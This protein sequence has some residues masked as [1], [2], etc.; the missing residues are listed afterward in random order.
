M[1]TNGLENVVEW[2][3]NLSENK[4]DDILD[5]LNHGSIISLDSETQKM[6]K[7]LRDKVIHQIREL[8][9]KKKVLKY[10]TGSGVKKDEAKVIYK[11][12]RSVKPQLED[13]IAIKKMN[14]DAFY[15]VVEF[16]INKVFVYKEYKYYPFN[17]LVRLGDFQKTDEA[18]QSLRFLFNMISLV[19]KREVRPS[20]L[21]QILI[22]DFDLSQELA[23]IVT[24]SV[25]VNL[26]EIQKTYLVSTID[27]LNQK[28]E[29]IESML[30]DLDDRVD[31]IEDSVSDLES[32][33]D[34]I[35]DKID[36]ID[37]KI[38]DIQN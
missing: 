36:D 26:D 7:K 3:Y 33:M 9:E 25:Q 24:E 38:D 16:I 17:E 35:D 10:L 19:C 14:S 4:R 32:L 27:E 13:S 5:V 28:V 2:F 23:D 11:Y 22:K 34:D 1:K 6:L 12:C 8:E 15:D 21:E 31:D 30:D 20:T 37:D 18:G 29:C